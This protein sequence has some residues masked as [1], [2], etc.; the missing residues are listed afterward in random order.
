MIF[1]IKDCPKIKKRQET[2]SVVLQ[3]SL[4]IEFE[5][6]GNPEPELEW[7]VILS[8]FKYFFENT[9]CFLFLLR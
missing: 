8:G 1:F 4:K 3:Q 2:Y 5:I 6:T 9:F 7:F